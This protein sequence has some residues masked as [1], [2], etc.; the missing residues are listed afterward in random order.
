EGE[1]MLA[2]AL[3]HELDHL[4]G[5][6]YTEHVE[7]PLLNADEAYEVEESE[8]EDEEEQQAEE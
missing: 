6:L 7:G 8:A 4:D 1:D 3:C 2:R 5:V